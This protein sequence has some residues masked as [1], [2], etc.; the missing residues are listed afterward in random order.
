MKFI[1]SVK[2][3]HKNNIFG[4]LA[5]QRM[6]YQGHKR[7]ALSFYRSQSVLGWSKFFV[8]DQIYFYH[9]AVTNILCQ[10]KW[11]FAFSKIGFCAGTNGFEVALNAVKFLGWLKKFAPAKNILEPVKRQSILKYHSNYPKN[12]I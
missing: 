1:L 9:V 4:T 11:W 5:N 8:P 6:S 3:K 12:Y 2:S 10:T 7:N